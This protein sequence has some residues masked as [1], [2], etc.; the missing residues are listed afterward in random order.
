MR[1]DREQ[2]MLA[3]EEARVAAAQA[4]YRR[5]LAQQDPSSGQTQ[6]PKSIGGVSR[7]VS[8]QH[9]VQSLLEESNRSS[10]NVPRTAEGYGHYADATGTTANRG[11]QSTSDG[12][13]AVPRKPVGATTTG[14]APRSSMDGVRRSSTIGSGSSH[15]LYNPR[16]ISASGS[17]KP[18]APPKKPA[19]LNNVNPG[20]KVGSPPKPSIPSSSIHV[21]KMRGSQPEVTREALIASEMSGQPMLDMTQAEK[22]DYVRDFQKRFPSLT[23]IEMV[24]RDLAA[25][26][27][28]TR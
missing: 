22:D 23:S 6:Y 20:V 11:P 8:I 13:P 24:E 10:S 28:S 4:E 19:Y 1:R 17:T 5:R 25:E 14:T 15:N 26:P 12:R 27:R 16:P 21:A 9:K 2:R 18:M 7:A 3:D